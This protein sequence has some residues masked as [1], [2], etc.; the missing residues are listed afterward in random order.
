MTN[1]IKYYTRENTLFSIQVWEELHGHRLRKYFDL[2]APRTI[3]DVHDGVA[4]VYYHEN[5]GSWWVE[6]ITDKSNTDPK[7]IENLMDQYAEQIDALEKIWKRG[8]LDT[9]EE[10]ISLFDFMADMWVGLSVS[11]GLPEAKKVDQKYQELGMEL[12]RR[13][14]DFLDNTDGVV[15]RTLKKFY[16]D[17][18]DLVKYLSIEEIRA[19]NIPSLEILRERQKHYVYFDFNILTNIDAITIAA[20]NNIHIIEE[21]IPTHITELK[22]QTAMKGKVSGIVRVLQ[23]KSQIKEMLEGEIL[24]TAMTTPDYLPA[25]NKASAFITDEGGITCHAAIV[26]REMGKP[27]IIGTKI[28]TKVFHN[29]D[30]VE[31]DAE[32]GTVKIIK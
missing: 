27:C 12:R 7:A 1:Y 20:E 31:V 4:F 13:S 32:K 15:L 18:G 24:V 17:L 19:D 14:V 9:K 3:F 11:Y 5:I 30:R 23:N 8:V 26:A 10:L 25:M 29:G 6:L 2:D 22:G 21:E 28:A 16:S